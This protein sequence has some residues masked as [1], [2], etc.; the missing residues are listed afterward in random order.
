VL[1]AHPACRAS[2]DTSLR[3]GVD[4][5]RSLGCPAHQL[6]RAARHGTAEET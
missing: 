1:F 4:G 3:R 6:R 2:L 5:M